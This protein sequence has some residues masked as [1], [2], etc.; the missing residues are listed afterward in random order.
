[1]Q[2]GKEYPPYSI[3]L[4]NV[5]WLNHINNELNDLTVLSQNLNNNISG[6]INYLELTK[7]FDDKPQIKKEIS[8]YKNITVSKPNNSQSE[9]LNESNITSSDISEFYEDEKRI[10]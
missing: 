6:G 8:E 7:I 10:F 2:A 4:G 9:S 5:A 1:M 3:P